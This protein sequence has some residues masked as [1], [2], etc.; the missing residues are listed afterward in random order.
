MQ[1]ATEAGSQ[2]A[3]AL[4]HNTTLTHIDLRGTGLDDVGLN[5]IG[6]ALGGRSKPCAV[7]CDHF[8]IST[9]ASLGWRAHKQAMEASCDLEQLQPGAAKILVSALG[10]NQT[11]RELVL[12]RPLHYQEVVRATRLEPEVAKCTKTGSELRRPHS[13]QC[14][15]INTFLKVKLQMLREKEELK[16]AEDRSTISYAELMKRDCPKYN[17][18]TIRPMA[19]KAKQQRELLPGDRVDF[20]GHEWWVLGGRDANKGPT[21][22]LLG[23]YPPADLFGGSDLLR[24]APKRLHM[25]R[26]IRCTITLPTATAALRTCNHLSPSLLATCR[27]IASLFEFALL[28]RAAEVSISEFERYPQARRL[29]R[30]DCSAHP[31]L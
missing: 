4:T 27:G 8:A 19:A 23:R 18:E 7:D 25:Y 5:S 24:H 17:G 31:S 13:W 11:L 28:F 2:I 30:L 20:E 21:S 15:A 9:A 10:Q 14:A 26:G 16:K 29:F 1:L 22:L 12:H 6:Q 3:S